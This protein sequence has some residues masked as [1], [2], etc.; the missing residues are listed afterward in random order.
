MIAHRGAKLVWK[1]S[2]LLT[3]TT[4]KV[5]WLSSSIDLSYFQIRF[6][7]ALFWES[8]FVYVFA[9]RFC[10]GFISSC[11]LKGSGKVT[12]FKHYKM[13]FGVF[14]GFCKHSKR[15]CRGWKGLWTLLLKLLGGEHVLLAHSKRE[16]LQFQVKAV[17]AGSK[18]TRSNRALFGLGQ[19]LGQ[20]GIY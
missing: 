4:A 10:S 19:T 20:L 1:C 16:H 9:V 13:I 2:L 3:L 14:I 17:A 18:F 5:F 6:L 7:P 11:T 12:Y 8:Q 15:F